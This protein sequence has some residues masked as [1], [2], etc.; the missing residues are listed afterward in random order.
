M[1]INT[2][3]FKEESNKAV[4]SKKRS[5]Y[6]T[7]EKVKN[8]RKNIERYGWARGERGRVVEKADK[9]LVLGYDFL[10]SAVTPQSLP[11]GYA[12]NQELGSPIT[13]LGINKYGNYP[14]Q[15]DPIN[16]P[17][18]LVDPSSRYIFP[19][20]DFGA[21]YKS[22]LDEQG[23]FNPD[24]ADKSL[25][26]NTLYP[27]KGEKWGVDDG[28]GWVDE[29]GK[30]WTFISYYN[31]WYIWYGQNSLIQTAL[32]SLR[33]AYVYTGDKKY[34]RVG[35]ILLDRIADVYP[36]MDTSVYHREDGYLNSD[37][38]SGLGR[39][40]GSIWE[41]G[42]VKEFLWA[43]DAFFPEFDDFEIVDFLGRKAE[44]H[45]LA[46]LKKTG[47][48]IKKNIEDGIVRQVYP[49]IK[50]GRIRGNNGMHQ[51]ALAL[52]A[53]VLDTL[54]ETKEWLDFNFQSGGFLYN[55][56]KVTGGNIA[57]TMVNDVDRDGMGDEAAPGYN[58]IWINQYVDVA[59]ILDGYDLCP[60][61]DLY[62]NPKFKKMFYPFY[63]LVLS[64][65]YTA[66]IGDTGFTGNPLLILIKDEAVKAFEKYGDPI[67][68]QAAYFLNDNKVDG[69]HGDIFSKDPQKITEDI[70]KIISSRGPLRLESIN[71][72]GYG[73][74]ALR[75]DNKDKLNV[76]SDLW[77]YYGRNTGHG[78]RDT[79]NIGLH[80]FGLDLA[81]DLGYPELAD[82]ISA[83]R[84][85]WVK[86]TI[87]HNTVMVNESAQE[88]N[89]VGIPKH[90]DN[91]DRVKLIDVEAPKVYP[92]TSL[93]RRTAALIK[94]DEEKSYV[95]DLFWIKEGES[96]HYSFHG[97]EA[98]VTTEGLN[99]TAQ[100]SGTYAGSEIEYP[101]NNY[102]YP[103]ASKYTG[104]GFRWLKNVEKDGNP[105][106]LFSVDWKAKDT[107]NIYGKGAGA[108]TDVHLRLTMLGDL[109]EAALADGI[110]PQN[111]PGNPQSLRYLIAHRKGENLESIFTSVIESYKQERY[112]ASIA[113]AEVKVDGQLID[114][115]DVK[116]LKVTL[117]NGRVDYII[118]SIDKD[119]VYTIE[120]KFEFK[121]FFG[122]YSE[123]N[124]KSVSAYVNEGTIRNSVSKITADCITGKVV[125]FTKELQMDNHI[126]IEI[127]NENFEVNNL[128]GRFIS[129]E[130]DG[131]R[132]ACYEIK[133]SKDV[134]GKR[135]SIGIGDITTIRSWTDP[136][137]FS[138]GYIYD[139]HEGARFRIPLSEE[140]TL[141]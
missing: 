32:N 103:G 98:I 2:D 40:I 59:N 130:N 42:L 55:D 96:H 97:P 94:I 110:P 4:N 15:A 124:N 1:D 60:S 123:E 22:G 140:K 75:N 132:N 79:L 71:M 68:A 121:G 57:A 77:L 49:S 18:K 8:A 122:V 67:F 63:Q 114:N 139:F 31:H 47:A 58:R 28:F 76:F 24:I 118:S 10:W 137:D 129:I 93:Y 16:M 46:V 61:A 131:Y 90:F 111:K 52:A 92:Q 112:I 89:I 102:C 116:A 99:L 88:N 11:R 39:I 65:I 45:K 48:E 91:S 73:F 5:T 37:G 113:A 108:D 21:Y 3:L 23:I 127:D 26:T 27:E 53:V 82:H 80:A 25:L 20:N 14:W 7:E 84:P 50:S 29:S 12:V 107:W 30:K 125:S 86:N 136:Y 69:I 134:S 70:E 104:S 19:T 133:E 101:G 33:D 44:E 54:P 81:P 62:K 100:G 36:N 34:A 109:K 106:D 13:G 117:K 17:W 128:C 85:E 51:S 87:S 141:V 135:V 78:H 95:V 120:D 6:F 66:G 35:V 9:Y 74:A 138:K 64:D 38:G 126:F 43:Y 56:K 119:A 72:T 105:S 41:T 83:M 115:A